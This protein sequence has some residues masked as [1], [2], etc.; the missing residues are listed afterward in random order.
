MILYNLLLLL[1]SPFMMI[2]WGVS[3]FKKKYRIGWK[4]RLGFLSGSIIA[5][6][7]N[8]QVIWVHAVSV[9]EVMAALPLIIALKEKYPDKKLLLSTVT[10]TGRETALSKIK[11]LDG[12]FYFPFD[13]PWIVSSVLNQLQPQ[14]F[15]FF[16]TEIWPNLLNA[17]YRRKIP[18]VLVNGRL[19]DRSFGRYLRAG[20]FVKGS[21]GK[22]SLC[23]MQTDGDLNRIISLGADSKRSFRTGNTK[24][25]QQVRKEKKAFPD[26]PFL[27]RWEWI[28]A[29]STHPGEEKE[30]LRIYR[31]LREIF[32]EIGLIL[33]PR[34]PERFSEVASLVMES[35]LPMVRRSWLKEAFPLSEG[36]GPPVF[37]LDSM[38]ELTDFYG[39]ATISFVGGSLLHKGGHNILEAALWSKAPFFGP[40]MENFR[41]MVL[42]FLDRGAAVQVK[43]GND[44]FEKM[45][46]Y[47][48]RRSEL[49]RIGKTAA[50]ILNENQGATIKNL[51]WIEKKIG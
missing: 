47:L 9:G 50:E 31:P 28:V 19:S 18:S 15:I 36:A 4:E 10:A 12:I 46:F 34:H 33:A 22:I 35:G 51:K 29:G 6:L 32:P 16:E 48:E 13:L 42:L 3:L 14:I 23:L 25:D 41:E 5:S 17:L 38:G 7:E 20:W 37:L 1:L 45:K 11:H 27:E 40:S 2:W 43:D 30:L 44:L 49:S 8:H 39:R 26:I 24:Y 21:V